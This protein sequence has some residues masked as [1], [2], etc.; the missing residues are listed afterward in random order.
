MDGPC[1]PA[2]DVPRSTPG[3]H[4]SG[5]AAPQSGNPLQNLTRAVRPFVHT[6]L[7][8]SSLPEPWGDPV[9]AHPVDEKIWFRHSQDP[10]QTHSDKRP[11]N[12]AGSPRALLPGRLTLCPPGGASS[13]LEP[14]VGSSSLPAPLS[15]W[16]PLGVAQSQLTPAQP[17]GGGQRGAHSLSQVCPLGSGIQ[18]RDSSPTSQQSPPNPCKG[19]LLFCRPGPST[20]LLCLLPS[21]SCLLTLRG[22]QCEG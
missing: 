7:T 4:W 13:F 2:I 10:S 1:D 9:L 11:P 14:T 5:P 12:P 8:R 3:A 6:S 15:T 21:G 16:A 17:W 18:P 22:F 19:T 20:F